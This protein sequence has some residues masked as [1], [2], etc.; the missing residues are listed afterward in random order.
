MKGE[1][2]SKWIVGIAGSV[3][4]FILSQLVTFYTVSVTLDTTRK[5][6]S[7]RLATELSRHFYSDPTF[8][9]VRMAIESCKKLYKSWGGQFDHDQL[10]SYLGYFDDL[11]FYVKDGA[12]DIQTIDH[13]YGAYII[14]AY[15]YNELRKYVE[16]MQRKSRQKQAL[17]DFQSLAKELE[18]LPQRQELIELARR[19]CSDGL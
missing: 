18:N 12:L 6:E 16:T 15:E 7:L 14:E 19:G 2:Q 1:S 3:L 17:A 13:W 11:G 9:D 5:I 4:G 8:K 10:N